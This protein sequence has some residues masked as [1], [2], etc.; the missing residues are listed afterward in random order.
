MNWNSDQPKKIIL[1]FR[2][3]LLH[4]YLM[5]GLLL[6]LTVRLLLKHKTGVWFFSYMSVFLIYLGFI[7]VCTKVPSTLL[8]RFRLFS[9]LIVM[10]IAYGSIK[11][12]VPLL[13][14]EPLDSLIS[15]IDKDIIGGD[16][17]IKAQ[18]IYSKPLTE[19]MSLG[20]MT[21]YIATACCF[22]AYGIKGSL[23]TFR[24]FC[25]G[26]FA[27][28][29]VGIT[30]YSIIPAEGPYVYF[31]DAYGRELAGYFFTGVNNF[32]VSTG[33]SRF[34]VFPSL[35]MGVG[36]Y[37]FMF[38][39]ANSRKVFYVYLFPFMVLASSTIYL[40]YH[41]LTDLI[42]GAFLGIAAYYTGKL[43]YMKKIAGQPVKGNNIPS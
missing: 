31:H 41:Y 20:Y 17:S 9:S 10:F 38:L 32:I 11:Y 18:S 40:R 5:G 15:S 7:F 28:F 2:N 21:Y 36:L 37:I 3:V 8:N 22:I 19:I 39:Y 13:G 14:M 27:I 33:S 16:L 4:E 1:I 30:C 24:R 6:Q 43:I 23:E 34:D 25:I 12:V 26:F 42:S 35:H 29:A